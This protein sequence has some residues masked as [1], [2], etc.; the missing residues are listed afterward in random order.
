MPAPH[1]DSQWDARI[2]RARALAVHHPAAADIL[3]FYA[4]LA[5]QQKH[6]ASG[7]AALAGS[8][9]GLVEPALAAIPDVLDW[10]EQAAPRPLADAVSQMRR[11]TPVAWRGLLKASVTAAASD[12]EPPSEPAAFV[13]EAVLQ[14]LAEAVARAHEPPAGAHEGDFARRAARCPACGGRPLVGL[15]REEGQ[16]AKRGLVCGLC[17]IDWDYLRVVCPACGEQRFDALPIY[18]AE[19]LPHV[20]VDACDSCRTYLKTID[21]T[22]DGHAVPLVDDLAT[23]ALDLWARQQGYRRLRPNLLRV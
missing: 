8:L 13:A 14:P 5:E 10:L 1:L 23:I 20:R 2:A 9:E 11:L 6:L 18:I 7:H 17:L 12:L 22:K 19:Q 21:L 15:L 16:G 3:T 4:A